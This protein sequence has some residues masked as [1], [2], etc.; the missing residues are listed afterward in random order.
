VAFVGSFEKRSRAILQ[1][2]D[3]DD[4]AHPFAYQNS[5]EARFRQSKKTMMETW[6]PVIMT[7]DLH[8]H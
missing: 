5:K 2:Q 8:L 7:R 1:K 3:R 4:T 6:Y